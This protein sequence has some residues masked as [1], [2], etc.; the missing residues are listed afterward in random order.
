MT[1]S[2]R[3]LPQLDT[4]KLFAMLLVFS[5]HCYFLRDSPQTQEV[6]SDYFVFSGVGVEFF[7]MVSGFFAAYTYKEIDAKEYLKKKINRLFPVHWICLIIGGYLIGIHCGKIPILTP[8]SIPLFQSLMPISGDTNPPSWTISTLFVLYFITPYLIKKLA[9]I[10]HRRLLLLCTLLCVFSTILNYYFYNPSKK[11]LFYFL[12]V[13]PYYR[14]VT[15]TIGILTGLYIIGRKETLVVHFV[16]G[17]FLEIIS[18]AMILCLM[19]VFHK[20]AG[21]WYTLPVFLLILVYSMNFNGFVTRALSLKCFQKIASV[22]YCF[23]LIHYPILSTLGYYLK[24]YNITGK[25][26]LVIALFLSLGLSFF[27]AYILNI[28]IEKPFVKKNYLTSLF[29]NDNNL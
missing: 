8:L 28:Y 14:I 12:Y 23:Y 9:Q 17:T 11:L 15:Y 7:I 25:S 26:M 4:L 6:Y 18:L 13:S 20:A 19:I 2:R 21:F 27:A 1:K 16:K 3:Y 29:S 24:E 5:T 10:P 22:S